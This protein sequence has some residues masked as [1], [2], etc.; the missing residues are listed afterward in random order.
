MKIKTLIIL[1]F[2]VLFLT[3]CSSTSTQEPANAGEESTSSEGVYP[4]FTKDDALGLSETTNVTSETKL[5][6]TIGL[7]LETKQYTQTISDLEALTKQLGGYIQ[8]SYIPLPKENVEYSNLTAYLSLMVPTTKIDEFILA[9]SETSSITN[10]SREA[11][12][13]TDVYSDTEA[14]ISNLQVKEARL[15]ELLKQSGTLSDLLMIET[16]LSNTRFEIERLQSVLKNY[17]TRIEYTQFNITIYEVYEYTPTDS[18]SIW[19]R[20][21]EEFSYNIQNLTRSLESAFI[22]IIST[23]PFLI[24]T[25]LL[26]ILV[27]YL[28]YKKYNKKNPL[29]S[30]L[31]KW[32]HKD[33]SH[34]T[35]E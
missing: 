34:Q 8:S 28:I 18:A 1:V 4:S 11:S 12:N 24:L 6:Q 22:F 3:S 27:V 29:K 31:S 17:D 9:T 15:I 16:E 32:K 14:H 23:L 26:P 10:E 20:I 19:D 13:V 5:I 25:Y 21:V 30:V 35:K 2:I 7:E 33:E